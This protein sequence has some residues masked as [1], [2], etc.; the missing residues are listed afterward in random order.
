MQRSPPAVET[1]LDARA[2]IGE[3]P[4]WCAAEQ[5]L[6]WIDIKAPAL[7]RFEPAGGA[8][9]TWAL[10][11]DVGGFALLRDP[12][13][14]LVALRYGLHRLDFATGA[15][16]L[17]AP[18][19]FDPALFR[20]NEGACDPDG[21]FW[22]G[23]MFDPLKPGYRTEKGGLHS[24]TLA[25]G[26]RAE[27]DL[28]DLHNGMAWSADGGAFYLSHSNERQIFVHS[29]DAGMGLMG[30]GALFA[31]LPKALGIPDGAAMDT[32]GGYWSACHGG[33]CLRR[34]RSDGSVDR[35]IRLPVSQ[36]TMC[37][38][39]GPN[40]DELYVT[41][42]RDKLSAGQLRKEPLAGGVFRVRPGESGALR[43]TF[44]S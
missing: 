36:P 6:Y 28:S 18:S 10:T 25:G 11:S 13:G 12:P 33:G 21:R 31:T 1:A 23:V 19:P 30:E 15:L 20:F 8:Q 37:A 17:L 22:I 44:A 40:L 35:D 39:G 4:L 43:S 5:A 26:L 34:Y 9:R 2:M 16:S 24:F 7:H 29:F 38:F 27:S 32:Q 41:S 42:A 14:A 3:S